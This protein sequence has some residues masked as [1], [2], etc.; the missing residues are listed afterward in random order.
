MMLLTDTR[1]LMLAYLAGAYLASIGLGLAIVLSWHGGAGV[2]TARSTLTPGE[3]IVLGL[4][5]FAVAYGL[6]GSRA[7][8]WRERRKHRREEKAE[9]HGPSLA[10]R[11]LGRGS[12]RVSFAL[13]VVLTLPGASYLVALNRIAGL[14]SPDAAKATWVV[15]FC[16]VQ[17]ALLEL[18]LLGYAIAPAWTEEAVERFRAWIARRGTAVLARGAAVV[19]ALLIARGVIELVA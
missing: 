17:L 3:D 6:A 16:I 11:L 10:E 4:L 18:P 12:P 15:V 1:R 19:G 7:E 9:A 5:A 14:E 13:G 2:G 8:P